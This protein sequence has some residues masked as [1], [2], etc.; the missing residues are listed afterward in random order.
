[1]GLVINRSDFSEADYRQ[2]SVRL[3]ENLRALKTLFERPDFGR[4][5]S[6]M[7]AELEMCIVDER[8]RA[9][10][11]N[12]EVLAD[13][14]DPNLQ[15]EL[16]RFN[17]EYNL[18]PVMSAGTPFSKMRMEL[19]NALAE[20]NRIA[21]AHGGRIVP[22][23]IL[24]T[25]CEDQVQTGAMT[26]LERYRALQA[27][28]QRI[29]QHEFHI[30]IDG[31]E[32]LELK[33]DSVTLEG[34]NTSFQVHLRVNPDEFA[35]YYNAAQLATP[36]ALAA[37]ANSPFFL[38]HS[39]WDETRIAL[40]KQS[41]DTRGSHTSEWRRAAR[42]PFG[43]GWV[44]NGAFELFAESCHLYPIIL[45]VCG[46][47]DAVGIARD[48][49]MPELLEL[50]LHQGTIWNWNR[51]VYDASAG[52]H[53][54][55]EFRALPSGPTPIDMMANAALLVGLTVGLSESIDAMLSAF[56]FRYAEYNFYRAAQRSLKADLLWPTL[57][58]NSPRVVDAATLCSELL[59]TADRG[60]ETIGVDSGERE[61]LIG[62]IRARLRRG[63]TPALWQRR[64]LE[65]LSDKPRE[66]ALEQL[67]L[68]YIERVNSGLP[69]SEW[70]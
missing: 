47:E 65:R 33:C 4:G 2:A 42:V 53:V 43:H 1:M 36:L 13:S 68:D 20:L 56:P 26:D 58:G 24:P 52:G 5:D 48:G 10:P 37:S 38:G 57:D 30:R 16:D 63:I 50:R 66:A 17:L 21:A 34:A 54:R 22:I 6:S 67:V 23:G 44:R 11:L 45:P 7:G 18:S 69:V 28:I 29:R 64:R 41:V 49:G 14:L 19:E 8:A 3:Q 25:L 39:L 59:E 32:P 60:L 51:A 15:L 27:G 46:Q 61:Q 35:R 31:D 70:P 9:L 62:V 40:F 55:I 12:R